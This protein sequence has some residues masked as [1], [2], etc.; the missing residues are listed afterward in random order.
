M[1]KLNSKGVAII[2]VVI[3]SAAIMGIGL[4]ISSIVLREI[5]I[6]APIDESVSAIMAAD[7]GMERKLFDIRQAENPD[8]LEEYQEIILPN[9][10]SFVVCGA[11][12]AT[13]ELNGATVVLRSVGKFQ[14][15]QRAWE[16]TY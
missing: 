11:D 3:I 13:C 4:G 15:T 7:A 2:V 5:K 12:E 14:N 9:G 6:S 16:A 1:M 10:A 8:P